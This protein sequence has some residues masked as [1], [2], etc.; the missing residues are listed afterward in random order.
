MLS[1]GLILLGLER[2]LAGEHRGLRTRE[3]PA[4]AV[5]QYL[6]AI[7]PGAADVGRSVAR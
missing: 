4:R 5:L 1:I 6:G 3:R 2:V 7:D